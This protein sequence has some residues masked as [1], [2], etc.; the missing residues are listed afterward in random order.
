M[1][2]AYGRSLC[3]ENKISRAIMGRTYN[4]NRQPYFTS[5]H[6]RTLFHKWLYHKMPA[7]GITILYG[8]DKQMAD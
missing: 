2:H 5:L 1:R 4:R 8:A 6:H 7:D 3:G